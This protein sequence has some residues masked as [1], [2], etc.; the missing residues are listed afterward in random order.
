MSS[1]MLL[2]WFAQCL[3]HK[4]RLL[5]V[6]SYLVEANKSFVFH[7]EAVYRSASHTHIK[8]INPQGLDELSAV[9]SVPFYGHRRGDILFPYSLIY[10]ASR[11]QGAS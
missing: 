7:L 4:S 9:P 5:K 10:W 2:S 1:V 11:C 3:H 8:G 6:C